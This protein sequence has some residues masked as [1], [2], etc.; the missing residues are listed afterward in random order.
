MHFSSQEDIGQLYGT[1]WDGDANYI[2]GELKSFLKGKSES[3]IHLHS[4]GGSVFDGNL[5]FNTL[6]NAKSKIHI[7]I[8]GLAAS[9]G[10]IIM[11]AGDRIS[12]ADNALIMIHAPS[13]M[14]YGNASDMTKAAGLLS[15]LE[16]QFIRIYTS[17]TNQSEEDVKEWLNGDN[18]FDAEQAKEKGLVDDIVGEVLEDTDLSAMKQMKIAAILEN[19]E[20]DFPKKE[21]PQQKKQ[22]QTNNKPKD[23]NMELNA[24]S[25]EI[26]GVDEKSTEKEVNASVKKFEKMAIENA[27]LKANAGKIQN[28]RILALIK[29]AIEDG[30]INA[31]EKDEWKELAEGNYALAASSLAKLPKKGQLPIDSKTKGE[32]VDDARKNWSFTDWSRKDT[33]GLLKMKKEDP[34]NYKALAGKSGISL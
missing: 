11:L 28:E 5:I 33:I 19:F 17:K 3:T 20:S 2:I 1:I 22:T 34:E 15:S 4:P 30:R 23:N 10:S 6:R 32:P 24:K 18:W 13:G 8:D 25:R 12:I 27:S 14:V 7:I 21:S 26:L 16:K 29:P 9:M 31:K